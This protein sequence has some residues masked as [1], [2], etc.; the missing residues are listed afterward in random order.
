MRKRKFMKNLSGILLA[1][2]MITVNFFST[3]SVSAADQVNLQETYEIATNQI[4]QWPRGPELDADTGIV[5]D[6]DTGAVLYE[7]GADEK[8]YPASIAKLMTLLVAVENSRVKEEVTFT[9]ICLRD[10]TPD[11]SNIGMQVGEIMSMKD[12]LF[13]M[14][15]ASAN[16]VSTQIAE[17][18]GGTEEHFIQ[19]MNERALELGCENTKF[20]NA[21]G[22]PGEGQYTTARDMAL[23]FQEVLRN[24][25][26]RKVITT[27]KYTISPTNLHG[28]ERVLATHHPM[29]YKNLEY[30]YKGCL[31]GK[32]GGT[33]D[34]GSTLVSG[35][36]R[37][38]VTYIAVVLRASGMPQACFDTAHLFDYAYDNFEKTDLDGVGAVT[39]PKGIRVE[40][41]EAR[42]T[43]EKGEMIRQYYFQGRYMGYSTVPEPT[44]VPLEEAGDA[45][46]MPLFQES[47]PESKDP[48]E[49]G[50][51]EPLEDL[52]ELSGSADDEARGISH[53][54]KILSVIMGIMVVLLLL[55]LIALFRKK[56]RKK[57][58]HRF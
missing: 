53:M 31:G 30:Y 24:K 21:N 35:A 39:L 44:E 47:G 49:A 25:T 5:M 19:M 46:E 32:T 33:N 10:Q 15:L 6:A 52:A 9:E 51:Q 48:I 45:D 18:V 2:G 40:E 42:D 57:Q 34:A 56:K 54:T 43:E 17:Y 22:L 58:K 14:M 12:C 20:I 41:L 11:S 37:D 23:I 29:V 4:P 27:W 16:E 36:K 26:A 28:E 7:K 55:L 50:E 38:G 13:A 8:R 1:A 3:V